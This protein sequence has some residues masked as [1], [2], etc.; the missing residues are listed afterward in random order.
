MAI[1]ATIAYVKARFREETTW[2]GI[3]AA[4]TGGATLVAP[5]SWLVIAAGIVAVLAPERKAVP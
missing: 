5:Y 4:I 3:I 1:S 2:L